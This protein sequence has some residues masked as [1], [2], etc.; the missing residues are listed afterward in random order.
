MVVWRAL[1]EVSLANL[2][3]AGVTGIDASGFDRTHAATHFAERTNLA[4]QQLKATLSVDTA[5]NA[6]LAVHVTTTRK[7]DSQFAPQR[8]KPNAA[9][10][11]VLTGDEGDDDQKPRHRGREL[12]LRLLIKHREFTPPIRRGTPGWTA[13][14]TVAET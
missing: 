2:P 3:T 1:L 4:I 11:A 6:V 12:G 7:H 8:V 5:T 14:C 13:T 10:I 9:S